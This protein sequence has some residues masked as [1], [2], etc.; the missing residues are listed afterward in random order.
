MRKTNQYGVQEKDAKKNYRECSQCFMWFPKETM[1][2]RIDPY[3][4]EVKN[5]VVLEWFC[6]EKCYKESGEDI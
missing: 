6:S 5:Q 4:E 2:K 1:E 3:K